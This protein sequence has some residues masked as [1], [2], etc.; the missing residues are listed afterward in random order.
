M[1]KIT[2]LIKY[3]RERVLNFSLI[4]ILIA[5]TQSRKKHLKYVD[6]LF[7]CHDNSRSV[8]IEG[9]R[10]A[11][12]IDTIIDDLDSD[13]STLTFALPFSLHFGK[14]CH[15][16]VVMYNGVLF[17]AYFSRFLLSRTLGLEDVKNDPVVKAWR[18]IL[19]QINPK[20]IL[21]VNPSSELCIV[22]KERNIFVGDVQHGIIAPGNY[23]DL[24]KR[25]NIKQAGWP[26]MIYCWDQYS[27]D[28]VDL[29]L[30]PY[31]QAEVIGHPARF[32]NA[33]KKLLHSDV[34]NNSEDLFTVLV[35]LTS[36]CPESHIN[37]KIFKDI[38]IPT[39]LVSFIIK[40]GSFCSWNIRLHPAQMSN[41]KN[42]VYQSLGEIFIDS[43]NV[44]W[45]TCN[46]ESILSS[47]SKSSVHITY[48]SASAREAQL[49]NVRT[50]LL[51][52]D[53]EAMNLYFG[54]LLLTGNA[55]IL[56]PDNY[57]EFKQWILDSN[58]QY[59]LDNNNTSSISFGQIKFENFI[60]ILKSR[61][62]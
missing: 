46:D 4:G 59:S 40:F 9:L 38:G 28:F 44:S 52:E 32:S 16:N 23:Y 1:A 55:K 24:N 37:D 57:I 27:K 26:N 39:S 51:D 2:F 49:F 13:I 34:S 11:P 47:L 6:I 60:K 7:L 21:G 35:T 62:Q 31:V 33:G 58:K 50:A 54:D 30:S 45:I 20:I 17:W 15:G 22:A 12:I 25:E 29:N 56:S 36:Y 3:L 53:V 10:Y 5:I 48:N 61:L 41:R 19:D 43:P 14:T 8:I 18:S 42:E